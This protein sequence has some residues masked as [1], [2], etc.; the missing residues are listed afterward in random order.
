M[1]FLLL[2]TAND[3]SWSENVTKIFNEATKNDN[4]VWEVLKRKPKRIQYPKNSKRRN[5]ITQNFHQ[6]SFLF[7]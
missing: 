6:S 2:K 3:L 1:I 7:L 5:V 4:T